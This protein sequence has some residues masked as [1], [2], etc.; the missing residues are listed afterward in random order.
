MS[1]PGLEKSGKKQQK[2]RHKVEKAAAHTHEFIS[3][4][5]YSKEI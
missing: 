5:M 4:K 3:P 2:K 1:H